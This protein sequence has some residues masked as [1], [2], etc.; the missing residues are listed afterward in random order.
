V[1]IIRVEVGLYETNC[2]IVKLGDSCIVIDPG[3]N[4]D[5]IC[6]NIDA[7]VT[8]VFLTHA[9]F[10]HIGAL[11]DVL[12]LYPEAKLCYSCLENTDYKTISSIASSCMSDVSSNL[13]VPK[14]DIDL[15]DGLSVCGFK[16]LH[17]PG[18]TAGSVCLY[19]ESSSVLF[20]GDTL[21]LHAFG[22]TDLG[23]SNRDMVHSLKR[24]F[25]L[26]VETVV[27]PGHGES[28]TIGSEKNYYHQG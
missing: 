17:T 3:D 4:R 18:H 7:P 27:Y 1:K 11:N 9:H 10:D 5:L 23:G 14:A 13:V 12:S 28:T 25:A 16:V 6:S 24:L 20:S 22:R 26:P 19:D 15:T 8:H 21:F 2:Y